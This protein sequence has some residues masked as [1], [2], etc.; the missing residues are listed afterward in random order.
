VEL[1]R[2]KRQQGH[3][4]GGVASGMKPIAKASWQVFAPA[5][6]LLSLAI[7]PDSLYSRPK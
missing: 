7:S 2:R 6:R 1:G 5:V 3:C 4:G